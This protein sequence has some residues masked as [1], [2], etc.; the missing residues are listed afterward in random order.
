MHG[1][2]QNTFTT[3]VPNASQAAGFTSQA[4]ATGFSG[5]AAGP[6]T[7]TG[8]LATLLALSALYI[9]WGIL[10]KAHDGIRE[11]VQPRNIAH[12]VHNFLT[13][14]LTVIIGLF[15]VKVVILKLA[16]WGVPGL[17]SV[18]TVVDAA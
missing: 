8:V 6:A 17:T 1:N 18:A 9:V 16:G 11:E 7:T 12:N 13:I 3:P 5:G 15:I 2:K 10:Q 14:T 4:A